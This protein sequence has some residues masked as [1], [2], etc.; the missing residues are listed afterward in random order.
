MGSP[1]VNV[2]LFTDTHGVLDGSSDV[3]N[4]GILD[5]LSDGISDGTPDG[6]DDGTLL[7]SKLVPDAPSPTLISLSELETSEGTS[8][9]TLDSS[10]EGANDVAHEGTTIHCM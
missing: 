3:V 7:G 10:S 2:S 4:D 6:I 9:D 5:G 1:H 8:D